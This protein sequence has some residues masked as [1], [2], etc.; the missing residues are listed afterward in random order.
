MLDTTMN[1]RGFVKL[2]AATVAMAAASEGLIT[3][4]ALAETATP[5]ASDVKRIRSCCRACGK[6]EC[7]VWVTVEDGKAV[8]VEGDNSA[9]QSRGNCCTKSQSSMQAAYHPDRLRY[10]MKRTNP[11]GEDPGWVRISW[12]EAWEIF[13]QKVKEI[14]EKYGKEAMM[15]MNGTSRAWGNTGTSI[16]PM[17][18]TPNVVSAGQV[19]KVPRLMGNMCT[20]FFGSYWLANTDELDNRVYVQWGTAAEYSNY[21]DSCRTITENRKNAKKYVLVDPRMT[22]MGKDADVWIHLRPGTDGAVAMSWIRTVIKNKLWDDLFV[23]RWTNASFLVCNDV[24]PTGYTVEEGPSSS[25]IKTRLLKESDLIEDGSPK[26][27][28]AYDNLNQRFCYYDAE[29]CV[30]EGETYE[31]PTEGREMC[32]GWLPDPSPFNPAKDPALYGEFEV[33]LK[34]GTVSKVKPV[35]EYLCAQVEKYTPEYAAEITG[36]SAEAIEQ[37]CLAWATRI[38]PTMPNGGIH[39]QVAVDQ[40]GNSIQTIRALSILEVICGCCDMPGCGRGGTF[41]NVSSSPVFLYPKSTGKHKM[42]TA[43]AKKNAKMLG[44]DKFPLTAWNGTFTDATSA[45]DAI[46]T[47]KPYPVVGN[48]AATG[49]FMS[50]TNS[51]KAWEALSKLDF[52]FMADLWHVPQA[53]MADVLVPVA[54]WLEQSLPRVSQGSSGG[55]GATVKCI[56]PPGEAVPET[57]MLVNMAR[58]LGVPWNKR[59]PENNP[60]PTYEELLDAWVEDFRDSWAE[61]ERDFQEHGWWNC[62]TDVWPDQF[63]TYRRYEMGQMHRQQAYGWRAPIDNLPGF[64][65]PTRR[66]EIWSTIIETYAGEEYVLPEYHEPWKSPV[67]T[68]ELAEEYPFVLTSGSR[69]P[70]F[71]HSEHRQLPWCRELWPAPRV[72]INPEDAERLGIE[73]G[74]WVWIESPKGKVRQVAD[75]YHGIAPGQVNANHTWWY[76]ELKGP[77]KGYDLSCIN[78]LV[79]EYDQDPLCGAAAIRAYLVKIYK[80]TPDNSPFNNPVPCDDDGTE[81]IYRSDDPRLKEWLPVYDSPRGEAL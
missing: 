38:D 20:D 3:Q 64:W 34:D 39:Y 69:T 61:F 30:W 24:E 49:N 44:A 5:A 11:K 25:T 77:K 45:W 65:T 57:I 41:G 76:P 71:F 63:G 31:A 60:Y 78:C 81:V 66:A 2:A 54:H 23:K 4:P 75:L 12:D 28:I 55:Q 42:A 62:K 1:R 67:S 21:D 48:V 15:C 35:W 7:G 6:M 58:T 19:C 43:N 17:L 29:A 16:K 22:P 27:F 72:E 80:A 37:G 36:A 74:D 33:T 47:G 51:N 10:P 73:Q 46:L 9:P 14:Q 70:T 52:F 32:G 26:K 50:M 68:P 8:R 56:D 40:C 53:Q 59:D 79:D 13:G 18:G